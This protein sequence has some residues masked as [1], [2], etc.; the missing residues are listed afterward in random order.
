MTGEHICLY[1]RHIYFQTKQV[2]T[3]IYRYIDPRMHGIIHDGVIEMIKRLVCMVKMQEANVR[4]AQKII[5]FPTLRKAFG[6]KR[7]INL[8]SCPDLFRRPRQTLIQK[9]L[10]HRWAKPQEAP[11]IRGH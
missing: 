7:K 11:K 2:D 9:C 3:A 10:Y 6:G 8:R 4:Q 1:Q 5:S